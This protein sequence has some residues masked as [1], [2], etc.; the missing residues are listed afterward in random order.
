MQQRWL[1][2]HSRLRMK[3]SLVSQGDQLIMHALETTALQDPLL[4]H[5]LPHSSL[6]EYMPSQVANAGLLWAAMR[7]ACS[8]K[9]ACLHSDSALLR[10]AVRTQSANTGMLFCQSIGK[11]TR[12]TSNAS[13]TQQP[14]ND[15]WRFHSVNVLTSSG[16]TSLQR[17]ESFEQKSG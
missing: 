4:A 10:F 1:N 16:R 8:D 6:V 11:C 3:G 7:C 17:L 9:N 2:H 13:R 5:V 15:F 14:R 12:I